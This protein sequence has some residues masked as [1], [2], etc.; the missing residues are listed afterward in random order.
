M[1]Y[2]KYLS[3]KRLCTVLAEFVLVWKCVYVYVSQAI[4]LAKRIWWDLLIYHWRQRLHDSEFYHTLKTLDAAGTL[5][6]REYVQ[7]NLGFTNTQ[8]NDLWFFFQLNILNSNLLKKLMQQISNDITGEERHSLQDI[9]SFP[10]AMISWPHSWFR[11]AVDMVS[12]LLDVARFPPVV[13]G[14][15]RTQWSSRA[16]V[17]RGV[18]CGN[19]R[20]PE[21]TLNLERTVA[22][23]FHFST[24]CFSFSYWWS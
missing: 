15:A 9:S 2:A 18:P 19:G 17:R 22:F 5:N 21:P 7:H 20:P 8:S 16:I 10:M 11:E 24:S 4:R 1:L 6:L 23:V 12:W 13:A 3:C 14:A